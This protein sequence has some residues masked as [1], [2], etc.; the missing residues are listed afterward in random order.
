MLSSL[1]IQ[2]GLTG[3]LLA[4]GQGRWKGLRPIAGAIHW[5]RLGAGRQT[6][7]TDLHREGSVQQA[8]SGILGAEVSEVINDGQKFK[9]SK[10]VV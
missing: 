3:C 2:P 9:I 10:G 1:G 8:K 4:A 6:M 7:R 5:H